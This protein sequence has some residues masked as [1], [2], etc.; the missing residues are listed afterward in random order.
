MDAIRKAGFIEFKDY[1][2]INGLL[3]NGTELYTAVTV[4]M[5]VNG[6]D[7]I[8]PQQACNSLMRKVRALWEN[9]RRRWIR[10]TPT[11]PH[12]D[13]ITWTPSTGGR[14]PF[15]KAGN[16]AIGKMVRMITPQPQ[17]AKLIRLQNEHVTT[18]W[19]RERNALRV[20]APSRRDLLQRLLRN[21]LPLGIKRVH[22]T[23]EAQT[24]CMLCAEDEV[25]TAD[26]IFWNCAFA[27][28][29]WSNVTTAWRNQSGHAVGW[30]EVLLGYE[31]RLGRLNGT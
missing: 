5:S 30:R 29:M 26:H 16:A 6:D 15:N 20:L 25:E 24:N 23:V 8:V 10:T 31:V 13:N 27:R 3:M 11:T 17:R 18:C 21:A 22:W 12:D 9:A 2:N 4:T 14:V 28:A 1:F 19:N 7:H